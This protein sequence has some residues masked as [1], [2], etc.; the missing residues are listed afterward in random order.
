MALRGILLALLAFAIFATHDVIIKFLGGTFSP[1]QLIFFSSLMSFP[2]AT[3]MLMRDPTEGNL[4]PVN[5]W[6]VI[7]RTIGT[8]VGTLCAFYAFTVLPLSQVYS[9]L[10]AMPLIITVL[11]VP[12]LGE[13]VGV[14]RWAAVVFGLAGVLIVLRPGS[15]DLELGHLAALTS[16]MCSSYGSVVV[17]RIG[18]QERSVVLMLYPLAA[19][20]I[21][22][23]LALPFVYQ[24]MTIEQL[25]L[26]GLIAIFAFSA[27]L[28]LIAAYKASE[29]A[30][31]APMQYS[32][33]LWA[34]V[35]GY[36]LFGETMDMPTMIGA[37]LIIASGIYIVLRE[38]RGRSQNTPV[39]RTRQR[40]NTPGAMRVAPFLRRGTQPVSPPESG[41]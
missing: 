29:A 1:F 20:F 32:Q 17:R 22:M 38:S 16:A 23:G 35:F 14:H 21:L 30:V 6:W 5:P 7:S 12:I 13:K 10:F 28:F 41:S 34:T 37:T 11:S 3:F 25:G 4:R 40:S 19:N 36:A 8:T 39:L 15:A 9:L 26:I 27:G 18:R 24:P 33:I 31:V 2:L